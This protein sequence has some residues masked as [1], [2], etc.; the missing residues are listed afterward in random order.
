MVGVPFPRTYF[1]EPR[2]LIFEPLRFGGRDRLSSGS[3][4]EASAGSVF[5]AIAG[6]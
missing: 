3:V 5:K 6:S 4:L 2:V 1:G